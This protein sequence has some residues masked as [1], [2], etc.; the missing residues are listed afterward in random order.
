MKTSDLDF[1]CLQICC[2]AEELNTVRNNHAPTQLHNDITNN[3][4]EIKVDPHNQ[5]HPQKKEQFNDVHK[6]YQ[7]AFKENFSII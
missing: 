7:K 1:S 6:N 3:Y 4:L 2:N 5:L